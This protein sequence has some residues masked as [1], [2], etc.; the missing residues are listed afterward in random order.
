ML[1]REAWRRRIKM[2]VAP[3]KEEDST[4]KGENRKLGGLKLEQ[5]LLLLL[6]FIHLFI[7]WKT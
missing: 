1:D 2:I 3:S 7:K 4:G 5:V 6:F